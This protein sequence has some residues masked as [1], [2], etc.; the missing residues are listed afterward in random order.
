MAASGRDVDLAKWAVLLDFDGTV[1][2]RDVGEMLLD[3]FAA[4]DWRKFVPMRK[5][6]IISG[7]EC[8]E[9][10][11]A[12]LPARKEE[13]LAYATTH[14]RLRPGLQTLADFCEK[15]G[16]LLEIVS[17]GLDFY[18]EGLLNHWGLGR[19]RW[20]AAKANFVNGHLAMGYAEGHRI[21]ETAGHCKC[22]RLEQLKD[23]GYMVAYGG[24]GFTDIC[25]APKADLLMAR[26]ALKEHCEANA[27]SFIS[28]D[29]FGEIIR[30]IERGIAAAGALGSDA[31]HT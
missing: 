26:G 23:R 27:M 20:T 22:A 5:A 2:E 7:R 17:C 19:L 24:D 29:D 21:C 12:C 18:I 3:T 9:R 1:T 25:P 8:L 14:A 15:R 10:E 6:G 30:H 28:C 13:L 11:F 31:R 16:I 4:G